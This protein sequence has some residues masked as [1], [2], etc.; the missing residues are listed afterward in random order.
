LF[1][2]RAVTIETVS[3]Y[4][5]QQPEQTQQLGRPAREL[6]EHQR[7]Q[8]V[9]MGDGAVEI[10]DGQGHARDGTEGV[11]TICHIRVSGAAL[12]LPTLPKKGDP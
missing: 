8:G 5:G 3:N 1:E 12:C 6:T 7:E 11:A 4:R 9:A 2:R 10:E